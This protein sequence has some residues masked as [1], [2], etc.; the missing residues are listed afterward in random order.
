MSLQSIRHKQQQ[1]CTRLENALRLGAQEFKDF[2]EYK[3][4]VRKMTWENL[5]TG[6]DRR[7]LEQASA[8]Q[9]AS[10]IQNI[11]VA[12]TFFQMKIQYYELLEKLI[13]QNEEPKHHS[14]HNSLH[15]EIARYYEQHQT[16]LNLYTF[17]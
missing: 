8:I 15:A 2:K 6:A 9:R 11:N 13:N 12:K 16:T 10:K 4:I 5:P 14:A 17:D 7:I 3:R 1:Y